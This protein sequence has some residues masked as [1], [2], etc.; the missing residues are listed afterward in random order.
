MKYKIPSITVIGLVLAFF[1]APLLIF[2]FN[3]FTKDIQLTNEM[4][5][6]RELALF[7]LTGLLLLLIIKGEK[8]SLDSIGLHNKHWGKSLVLAL[9][10]MISTIALLA[11]ILGVFQLLGIS[12]GSGGE[13]NRYENISLT[14]LTLMMF[15]AGVIEEICY[16]GFIMERLEK[17]T[18]NRL[19]YLYLPALIFGLIHYRQGVGGIIIATAAGLLLALFYDKKRDLKANI[20]AHFSVDLIPNVLIPL[21]SE[22][23]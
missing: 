10:I 18:G 22:A 14:V 15:R 8:L 19:I 12:F 21:I 7:F 13:S 4:V 20:I 5:V 16:R 2:V 23:S 1:G 17:Y 3:Q 6:V 11:G 9:L